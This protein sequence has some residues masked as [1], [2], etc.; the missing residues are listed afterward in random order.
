MTISDQGRPGSPEADDLQFDEAETTSP[1][2]QAAPPCAGCKQPI[3]D[4]YYEVNGNLLCGACRD[5][6]EAS[7]TAGSGLTR[8]LRAFAFGL[9][10]A[11]AGFAIYYGV[12][13]LFSL[14]IG[15]IS[16]LVGFMVGAAVRA[17]SRHRG[18]PFYQTLAIFLTYSAI[19]ASYSAV[20]L[21]MFLAAIEERQA[22]GPAEVEVDVAPEGEDD[23]AKVAADVP[24]VQVEAKSEGEADPAAEAR[25]AADPAEPAVAV[26]GDLA[27][28]PAEEFEEL[29]P[30]TPEE[31]ALALLSMVGF[32]F[33]L[34]V[35]SGMDNPIGLL[36]VAF[37]LWE[38]W[39][40]NKRQPLV[41]NGP[42][43]IGGEP[44]LGHGGAAGAEAAAGA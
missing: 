12:M 31:L 1:E 9:G 34:P 4:A 29:A 13:R 8:M 11:V 43:R 27:L 35:I 7:R 33:A 25:G 18:G 26:A 22:G 17:G 16:I 30:L 20:A 23:V 39:K 44:G 2:P 38:A 24:G 5:A 14:E 41:I 40:L 19:A 3:A 36:I 15:L 32:L 10:A 37:A 6:V 21:P 42:F 28:D